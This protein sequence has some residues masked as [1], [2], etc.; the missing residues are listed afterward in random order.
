M[1]RLTRLGPVAAALLAVLLASGCAGGSDRG[2]Q[3]RAGNTAKPLTSVDWS[4]FSYPS[5]CFSANGA[6]KP[7]QVDNYRATGPDGFLTM[8]VTHPVFG[9]IDGDGVADAALTYRCIGAN[10]SPDTLLVYL[11]T[12]AGPRLVATLLRGDEVY[13]D[14]LHVG[15]G[16]VVV[17]GLG[18]SAGTPH[19]CPDEQVHITYRWDGTRLVVEQQTR[20]PY[21]TS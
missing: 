6:S 8:A 11:A 1:L 4:T 2:A 7:V 9:D 20:T 5:S 3:P 13:V 16:R 17:S 15:S 18:Y 21:P 10:A 12:P 19:C 14:S